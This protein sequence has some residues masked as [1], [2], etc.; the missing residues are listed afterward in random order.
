MKLTVEHLGRIRSAE[1]DLRPLTVFVGENNTNKS[2]AAYAAYGCLSA[3]A[4]DNFARGFHARPVDGDADA[5]VVEELMAGLGGVL[6]APAGT[7]AE[8]QVARS[9]LRED[10]HPSVVVLHPLDLASLLGTSATSHLNFSGKL[11]VSG[12]DSREGR[13]AG[14]RLQVVAQARSVVITRALGRLAGGAPDMRTWVGPRQGV[15][16][17]LADAVAALDQVI[18]RRAVAF[19]VERQAMA[20][21]EAVVDHREEFRALRIA[22]PLAEFVATLREARERASDGEG[23]RSPGVDDL[24][25]GALSVDTDHAVSFTARRGPRLPVQAAA[26][27][28][29]SLAGLSL[30]LDH[31]AEPGD[32]LVIDEPEMNAHPRAQLGLAEL[33][34]TLANRGFRIILTTHSPYLV[35]HL[36]NLMVGSRLPPE[37]RAREAERLVLRREDAYLDPEKVAVYEFREAPRGRGVKPVAVLDRDAGDID[38]R[39]FGRIS[40]RVANEFLR[41]H[42]AEE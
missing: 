29:R 7:E 23:Q 33:F 27:M 14:C 30:Y 39:T 21:L 8:L 2:W 34:A 25:G 36:T 3:L 31:L 10:D 38:T 16:Q 35:D 20:F 15:R 6:D 9:R 22:R 12:P 42:G 24:L 17:E 41:L 19:P 1:F 11:E 18:A 40:D 26:S 4:H 5:L 32:I 37:R 28:V 13:Y